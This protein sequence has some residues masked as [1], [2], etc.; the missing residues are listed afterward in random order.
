MGRSRSR[1]AHDRWRLLMAA[2][3]AACLVAGVVGVPS[4]GAVAKTNAVPGSHFDTRRGPLVPVVLGPAPPAVTRIDP[5]VTASGVS[6]AAA[7]ITVAYDNGFNANFA[8]RTA[9]QAAVNIWKTQVSSSVPI[10]INASFVPLSAGVLGSA[11]PHTMLRTSSGA[12]P[13]ANYW[14]P[15]ALAN[16][17]LGYDA[18]PANPDIEAQF[19]NAFPSWYFGTDG[20]PGA[21]Q[22]D[23]ET[24]VLHELGHGLG[25]I[26][27]MQ[28]SGGVG[29]WGAGTSSPAVY[30]HFTTS[31]GNPLL[32]FAN[33]SVSLATA[34]QTTSIQFAGSNATAANG[35]TP[36]LL[37]APNPWQPGS[38]YAH[39][40]EA[41]YPAGDPNSLMTPAIGPGES[42]HNPGPLMLGLFKDLGWNPA[43]N[44]LGGYVVDGFGGIHSFAI[45]ANPPP[46][47]VSGGPY[48]LGWDIA[49]GIAVL[50]DGTG[51]Y[52]VDGFGGVHSFAIGA[53]P[54]PPDV[55]GGPYWLGWDIARGIALS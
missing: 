55:S 11:G 48:W 36:P 22:A 28:V 20:N 23:F 17:I 38:S 45:G 49:R 10:T 7:T 24:V 53:N 26:G 27:T 2:S 39:F 16:S 47:A 18:D 3:V 4:S 40:D 31:N 15:V 46:A 50:P 19:S 51:G 44:T 43:A 34:L 41:A 13:L 52:V 33:S 5:P 37:F 9:F 21:G 25:F 35:G 14:Y 54:P 12:L 30:D 1:S 6:A 32:N 42:I 29:S 8:A